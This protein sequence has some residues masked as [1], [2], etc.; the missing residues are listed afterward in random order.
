[1][2]SPERDDDSQPGGLGRGDRV[3]R[4]PSGRSSAARPA[5]GG[6]LGHRRRGRSGA[7]GPAPG[8]PLRRR[9]RGMSGTPDPAPSDRLRHRPSGSVGARRPARRSSR[10][11][12]SDPRAGRTRQDDGS[13]LLLVIGLSTVLLLLVAVVVDVS[14]VVLAK[15]GL[16]SV[17]DGAAVAA[18]QQLDVAAIRAN[19][20]GGQLSLDPAAV[21][22]TVASYQRDAAD[23]QPGLVL[24]AHVEAPG[25]AVVDGSR[26][27]RLPFVG[28]LG[29]GQVLL[30]SEGRARSPVL[31]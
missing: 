8:G 12:G 9:P 20:L 31:P 5:R 14:A 16:S 1:M 28:W 6:P 30:G 26:A 21:D 22:D 13:V 7:P 18:A 25:T 27:I 15:R 2:S 24:L 23:A 17:V 19:G 29:I 4:R 10:T 11:L 3:S